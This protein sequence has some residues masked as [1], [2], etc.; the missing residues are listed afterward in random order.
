MASIAAVM[1]S[2]VCILGEGFVLHQPKTVVKFVRCWESPPQYFVEFLKQQQA[3]RVEILAGL[4]DLKEGLANLKEDRLV[5][6]AENRRYF[7]ILSKKISV[8]SEESVRGRVAKRKGEDWTEPTLIQ[9]LG[10]VV[11]FIFP[12]LV[13]G[14]R[15]D[16]KSTKEY[17]EKKKIA[18][19]LA[20]QI[21]PYLRLYLDAVKEYFF[22]YYAKSEKITALTKLTN[23]KDLPGRLIGLVGDD[24]ETWK[25]RL[26][27]LKEASHLINLE[28]PSDEQ[29]EALLSPSGPGIL[30]ACGLAKEM[31]RLRQTSPF[32]RNALKVPSHELGNPFAALADP[33]VD[34]KEEIEVRMFFATVID[35]I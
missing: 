35:N 20:R 30:L 26:L 21:Q 15:F 28:N 24:N 16:S 13:G 2:F 14:T 18:L 11:E 5:D 25:R 10:D 32:Q 3:D 31:Y 12:V 8:L 19:S 6:R 27:R 33:F 7:E 4:A 17:D 34:L 1:I 9:S 22:K 23:Y 29:L